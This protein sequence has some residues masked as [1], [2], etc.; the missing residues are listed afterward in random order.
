MVEPK[1]N[2]RIVSM[3][4]SSSHHAAVTLASS[5]M[6][7]RLDEIRWR[8]WRP[9]MLKTCETGVTTNRVR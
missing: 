8:R 6:A 7:S 9:R 4:G 5:R 1:L 2:S 3:G